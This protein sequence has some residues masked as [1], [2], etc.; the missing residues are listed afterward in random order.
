MLSPTG[1]A[2][3]W[4]FWIS[5]I[6]LPAALAAHRLIPP[7]PASRRIRIDWV[8]AALLSAALAAVLLAVTEANDWGWGSAQTIGLFA[9]GRLLLGIWILVESA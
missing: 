1:S 4:L 2:F 9:A 8:G 5:L 6:A 3:Q 7:S